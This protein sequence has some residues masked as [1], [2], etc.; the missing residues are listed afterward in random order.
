MIQS[1]VNKRYRASQGWP[2]HQSSTYVAIMQ[3]HALNASNNVTLT[4]LAT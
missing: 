4:I 1:L 3:C 2:I